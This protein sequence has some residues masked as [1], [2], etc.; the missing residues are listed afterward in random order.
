MKAIIIA[1]V[2]LAAVASAI[3]PLADQEYTDL[4]MSWMRQHG[5]NNEW[6]SNE[7]LDR[8]PIFKSNLD[9]IRAH[10]EKFDQ[11]ET[12]FKLAMNQ[13]GAMSNEEYRS[14]LRMQITQ[15]PA[16]KPSAPFKGSVSAL[17]DSVDWRTKGAVT[18]V[19]D[20][21]Q[22]GSCWAFS[23]TAAMEGANW[24]A[25]GQ[26]LSLSEQ[27]CVDCVLGGADTCDVG[28]E[29]HDCYT[30]VIAQGGDNLESDYPYLATSGHKCNFQSSK[31]VAKMFTGY[32][33]VT[34]GDEASLQA[35]VAEHVV[36]IGIDASQ[37]SFQFYSS[38]VYNE[39]S[40]KS[41]YD[42]LDHGVTAVGYGTL[43]GVDYWTVKNSWGTFWGNGGYILMSRNKS[44][45]CG[46]ATDA[47]YPNF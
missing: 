10:N 39:P 45:Q 33:N 42:E 20:Q 4:Y 16:T 28:G 47:T 14:M 1:V 40:C 27:L 2:G 21:G 19:K 41:A 15:D 43:N 13:F 34:S 31:A 24:L 25:T 37:F 32:T 17:P 26:L 9:Q 8:F 44:N 46:V 12:T 6:S 11:G 38:G 30:Q 36:S 29:M 18:P 23:A 3:A 35:A 5:K 22:C 7:M